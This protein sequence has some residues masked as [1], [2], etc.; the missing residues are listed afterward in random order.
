M[1]T[2]DPALL[3]FLGVQIQDYGGQ[4]EID[5]GLW[6]L[7]A[8]AAADEAEQ[9]LAHSLLANTPFAHHV[10]LSADDRWMLFYVD[11]ANRPAAVFWL[12]DLARV[13]AGAVRPVSPAQLAL[14]RKVV[15]TDQP[16]RAAQQLA[17]LH[18]R[19]E[20]SAKCHLLWVSPGA[21]N[22]GNGLVFASGSDPQSALN[23]G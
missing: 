3:R 8:V 16:H 2:D 7:F 23:E 19:G 5:P 11:S 15:T 10:G 12:E 22:G 21:R 6:A 1:A 17:E 9:A 13:T 4:L 18:T 14:I 20:I